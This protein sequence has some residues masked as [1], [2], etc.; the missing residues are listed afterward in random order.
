MEY[1]PKID[2]EIYIDTSIYVTHG[3]DD[4][5]GGICTITYVEETRPQHYWIEIA[6]D[7]GRFSWKYD[8]EEQEQLKAKFGASRG[9][10]R[11][12]FRE[13]FNGL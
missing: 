12:D 3:E 2:D 6:E 7:R 10:R 11:P 8:K 13:E 1:I 9:H 4:F 5:I